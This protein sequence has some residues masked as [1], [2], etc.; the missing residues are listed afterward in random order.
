MNKVLVT[1]LA[2]TIALVAAGQSG[3]VTKRPPCT[4]GPCMRTA[5]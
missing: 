3:A 1:L 4:P 2:T 5:A